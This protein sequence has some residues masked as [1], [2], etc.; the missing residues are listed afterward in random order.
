M[1]VWLLSLV[2]YLIVRVL[3]LFKRLQ[4]VC[5]DVL[6]RIEFNMVLKMVEEMYLEM[7]LQAFMNLG[8]LQF[9]TKT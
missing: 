6:K 5:K 9:G 2:F 7:T 3:V 4:R 1:Q 8:S